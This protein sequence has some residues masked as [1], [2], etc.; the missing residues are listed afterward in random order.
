[1]KIGLGLPTMFPSDQGALVMEWARRADAAGFSTLAI[2]DR[3][4]Y[5]NF[6]SLV[7]LTAAAAV[8]ERIRLMT[9]ILV[10]PLRSPGVLA[11][12]AASLDALSSGRLTLGLA[13]GNRQDDFAA[14]DA[15]FHD[16]GRRFDRQLEVMKSIWTGGAAAE[17]AGPVGPTPVTP[18][19]PQLIIGGNS[20]AAL[21]RMARWADGYIIGP[22]ADLGRARTRLNNARE[23]WAS[24]GRAGKQR[25]FGSLAC[26]I[27]EDAARQTAGDVDSYDSNRR[28]R[29]AN[30]PASENPI[31][32]TPEAIREKLRECEELGLDE[33]LVR[34]AG[35]TD[36]DQVD[37]LA[38]AVLR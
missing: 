16:R 30:A 21:A 19:G 7:T 15:N 32:S 25:F 11:K 28:A 35:V 18:G 8:T 23:A 20:D 17:D 38:E 34:P 10:A 12:Q 36:S 4:V 31:P 26:A 22:V 24:Q 27:G 6:E 14:A 5:A 33:V 9:A 29:S 37:R 13:V 2:R 1:M 3:L